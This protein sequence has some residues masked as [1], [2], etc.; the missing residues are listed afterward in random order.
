MGRTPNL[1]RYLTDAAAGGAATSQTID[2][3]C[4]TMLGVVVGNLLGLPIEGQSRRR[5]QE[6]YPN[7][8]TEIRPARRD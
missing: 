2:R 7:G 5:I 3:V 6:R 4:G 1:V 8:V